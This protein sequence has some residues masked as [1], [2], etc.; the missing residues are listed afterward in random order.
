MS[1]PSAASG[2]TCPI[3]RP[4]VPPEKRTGRFV[5]VLALVRDGKLL[6]SVRAAAEGVILYAPRGANGFGYDPLFFDPE[7]NKTFAE[8]T[9]EEKLRRSHRG[10]ALRALLDWMAKRSEFVTS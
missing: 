4:E 2:E 5:C 3:E 9:T 6:T 7:I 1:P 8:L 10:K